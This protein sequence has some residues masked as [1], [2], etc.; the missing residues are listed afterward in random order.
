MA[1]I[2][3][4]SDVS[5]VVNDVRSAL[6]DAR[7]SVSV[8]TDPRTAHDT[9]AATTPDAVLVDFQVGSMG[10]MAVTRAIRD[11]AA[12]TTGER[13]PIVLLMDRDAD[14]FLAGRSGADAWLRKPFT[15]DALRATLDGLLTEA[16]DQS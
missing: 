5:W 6:T 3:V 10:G 13:P 2:L 14:G 9:V 11:A 4:V 7:F 8:E 12:T 16:P 15:A 1:E